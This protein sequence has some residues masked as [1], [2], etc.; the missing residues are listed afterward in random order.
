MIYTITFNPAIDL[1]YRLQDDLYPGQLNRSQNEDYIMGGKG[2][3]ASLLL[4]RLGHDTVATGFL[5]GFTGD[6]IKQ[7]LTRLGIK[8]YFITVEGTTRINAKVKGQD[9]TEINGAGPEIHPENVQALI[10]YLQA[11]LTS[12]DVVFLAGNKGLGMSQADYVAI[13]QLS[14]QVGAKLVLDSNADLL[15]SCLEYHPFIIKPNQDELNEIFDCQV[16][17]QSDVIH[18]AKRLQD[19]GAKH[20]LVS[21]GGKG[22]ILV[23]EQGQILAANAPKGQVINSTG[24]GDSMLAGF[25]G[26]YLDNGSLEDSLRQGAASGSATAFS[27]GIAGAKAVEQLKAQ[28]KITEIGE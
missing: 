14:H 3:N 6:F 12:D 1:I 11:E 18:Y 26:Q 5:A 8:P 21:L 10:D 9:E 4:K 28:I 22:S 27:T 2:L 19:M 17:S 16:S 20:V 7:E 13:A 15:T 24:A 23:T 25:I